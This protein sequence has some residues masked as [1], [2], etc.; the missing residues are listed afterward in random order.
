MNETVNNAPVHE[1]GIDLRGITHAIFDRILWI[2]GAMILCMVLVFAYTKMTFVPMYTSNVTVYTNSGKLESTSDVSL[3]T[4]YAEDFA[5]IA[6][7]R[8]VLEKAIEE[9]DLDTTWQ[10]FRANLTVTVEEES[11]V[12]YIS[13]SDSDPETAQKMANAVSE[14]AKAR[15][16]EAIKVELATTITEATLPTSPSGS[17]MVLKLIIA[18]LV[19]L[20]VSCGVIIALHIIRD[21]VNSV[22]D[23]E[24]ALGMTVLGV[25][26]FQKKKTAGDTKRKGENA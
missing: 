25:I 14:V 2:A 21:R 26:P 4:F 17:G 8:G 10:S 5:K 15:L 16:A 6:V 12:V 19:G 22:E 13:V 20:L 3:P 9:Y 7:E 1:E 11:R 24:N 23:V 18:A